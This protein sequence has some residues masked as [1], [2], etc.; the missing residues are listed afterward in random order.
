MTANLGTNSGCLLIGE[1][2]DEGEIP[3]TLAHMNNRPPS[4][5]VE[6]PRVVAN[7]LDLW[8]SN[9]GEKEFTILLRDNRTVTVRGHTIQLVES[10]HSEATSFAVVAHAN[11][12]DVMVAL[13]RS[14][15][16]TGIFSGEM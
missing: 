13:F 11:G 4:T 7:Y 12:A 14:D 3:E 15:E 2:V 6:R 8:S 9:N 5:Q 16:V 10:A 1:Y